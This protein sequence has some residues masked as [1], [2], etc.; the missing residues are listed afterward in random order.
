MLAGKGTLR[1][2]AP[3]PAVRRSGG[4]RVATGGSGGNTYSLPAY[5]Q[6]AE[7]DVHNSEKSPEGG[8]VWWLLRRSCYGGLALRVA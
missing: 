6:I 3:L 8:V 1:R 2:F 5:L 4:N 7:L